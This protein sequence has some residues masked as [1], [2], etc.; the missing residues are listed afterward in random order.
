M[1]TLIAVGYDNPFK[2]EEV[3]LK[4]QKMQ[5]AYLIDLDDAVVAIKNAK[6]RVKLDQQTNLTALGAASGG[7]WGALIGL[8]FLA[9]FAGFAIGALAGGISGALRDVGIND[10]FMKDLADTMKPNTSALFVLV[11]KATPDR[12]LEEL[13]GTG[14]KILQSS[15]SH[16]EVDRL[17]NVLAEAPAPA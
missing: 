7:F 4:L 16:E 17:Q 6:G 8:I 12:V 15:L 3:R 2:A 14:G 1:S 11:R 13:K 10:Q 9:P 5:Q